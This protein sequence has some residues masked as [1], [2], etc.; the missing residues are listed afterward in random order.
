MDDES[1]LQDK[2]PRI[3]PTR[4]GYYIINY[5]IKE[6]ETSPLSS[7]TVNITGMSC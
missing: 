7:S 4:T 5:L 2:S 6:K 1:S 3:L